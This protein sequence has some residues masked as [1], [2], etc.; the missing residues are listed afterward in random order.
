M[1]DDPTIARR[2]TD[3]AG[4]QQACET[5]LQCALDNGGRDNVTVI[6]AGYQLPHE[7]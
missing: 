6:V 7:M 3:A 1:V 5:L 2:L 4:S